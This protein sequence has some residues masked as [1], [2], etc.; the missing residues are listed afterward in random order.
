MSNQN[1]VSM[2]ELPAKLKK[3]EPSYVSRYW[4]TANLLRKLGYKKGMKILDVGGYGSLLSN[5]ID[6]RDIWVLDLPDNDDRQYIRASALNMPLDHGSYD[7]VVSCDVYEHIPKKDREKFVDET[8]RVAKKFVIL[9][10]PFESQEVKA[11]EKATNEYYKKITGKEHPWLVEH[12]ANGLPSK[13]ELREILSKNNLAFDEISHNGVNSWSAIMRNHFVALTYGRETMEPYLENLYKF[14]Y[15]NCLLTD[16]GKHGYRTAYVISK[17]GDSPALEWSTLSNSE[18]QNTRNHQLL[19]DYIASNVD[20]EL[21]KVY[22]GLRA[23]ESLQAEL[24]A[25]VEHLNT[26]LRN[27]KSKLSSIYDS[28]IWRVSKPVRILRRL[29]VKAKRIISG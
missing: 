14:Y 13:K 9:C 11:A 8:L 7:F 20:Q 28:K 12:I 6:A 4:L 1:G 3:L 16:F 15:D 27:T 17:N 18:D 5:F 22:A 29:L 2:N 10:A 26:E 19:A 23:S 24:Q 21:L 25:K